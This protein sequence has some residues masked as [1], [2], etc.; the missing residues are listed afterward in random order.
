MTARGCPARC[1]FCCGKTVHG[2]V[3]REFSVPR[4]VDE[5]EWLYRTHRIEGLWVIDDTFSLKEPRVVNFCEELKR[6]KIDLI[7]A[8]QARVDTFT[9]PM[10]K[11]MRSS[12]C[13]Q[14]DFGV[15][16][17]SQR[18]LDSL[19]KG[20]K[21]DQ[22][23]RAFGICK[24]NGIRPVATVMIGS[25]GETKE[26]IKLTKALLDEIKPAFLGCFFCTPFPGTEIY[27][28]AVKNAWIDLSKP[29][30]WQ[31]MEYPVMTATL[32]EDELKREFEVMQRYNK[33]SAFG[34]MTN[35]AFI[36]DMLRMFLK[37]TDKI[38]KLL[39]FMAMGRRR[40][41]INTFLFVFRKEF[42]D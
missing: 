33:S 23:K 4:V 40:D 18:V 9:E 3:V 21:V 29:V 35:P 37:N 11:A 7:W 34:Y 41:A 24:R 14:I 8:C 20:I 15:E 26:D 16:S 19:H 22:T 10:A 27:D 5:V 13:V 1:T 17:G 25:P 28:M 2:R 30:N 36:Y 38:L 42:L 31:T 12:G 32:T 6:R 39:Y